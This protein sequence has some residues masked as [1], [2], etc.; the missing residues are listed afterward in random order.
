MPLSKPIQTDEDH[1]ARHQLLHAC[2]DELL[3]DFLVHNATKRP[4][5]TSV[6]ELLVWSNKQRANPEGSHDV[7]PRRRAG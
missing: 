7:A 3:A 4:S 5:N 1:R 2:L 6:A